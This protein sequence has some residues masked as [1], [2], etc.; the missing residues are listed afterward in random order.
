[1]FLIR[2]L[3]SQPELKPLWLLAHGH[4]LPP[5][6]L[7]AGENNCPSTPGK[8]PVWI[9]KKQTAAWVYTIWYFSICTVTQTS[10][11]EPWR[12]HT[13]TLQIIHIKT[14][15]KIILPGEASSKESQRKWGTRRQSHQLLRGYSWLGVRQFRGLV[16]SILLPPFST[17]PVPF[18]Q[19]VFI[20]GLLNARLTAEYWDPVRAPCPQHSAGINRHQA[21]CYAINLLTV[22]VSATK[23]VLRLLGAHGRWVGAVSGRIS[24]EV[25]SELRSRG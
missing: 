5:I 11:S 21:G 1:M 8:L 2:N 24:N 18:I 6:V 9:L 3:Q 20:K 23:C 17:Y 14:I 22:Q 7:S 13:Q 25:A 16:R 15:S 19:Q 12:I 4:V 10:H